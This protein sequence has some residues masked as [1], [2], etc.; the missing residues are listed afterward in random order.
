[1]KKLRKLDRI[2]WDDVEEGADTIA[3]VLLHHYNRGIEPYMEFFGIKMLEKVLVA[4]Y[5]SSNPAD[6]RREVI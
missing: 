5:G 3:E 2:I 6:W 4:I 1:M